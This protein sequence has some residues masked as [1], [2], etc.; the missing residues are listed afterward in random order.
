MWNPQSSAPSIVISRVEALEKRREYLRRLSWMPRQNIFR[1]KSGQS[2]R[3]KSDGPASCRKVACGETVYTLIVTGS[4]F[5][6]HHVG[7]KDKKL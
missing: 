1:R 4:V 3:F 2:R 6:N 5:Q 7:N